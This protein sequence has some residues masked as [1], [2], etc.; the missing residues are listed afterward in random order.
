MIS[1]YVWGESETER[2]EEREERRDEVQ[3]VSTVSFLSAFSSSP[4]SLIFG[5]D[6]DAHV[7]LNLLKYSGVV[8]IFKRAML[9]K[10]HLKKVKGADSRPR[11]LVAY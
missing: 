3:S 1:V 2:R 11:A 10:N 4:I 5:I 9:K 6:I 7:L 8:F